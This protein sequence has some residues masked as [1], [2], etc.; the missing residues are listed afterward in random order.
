MLTS[1]FYLFRKSDAIGC[2]GNDISYDI[3]VDVTLI[4]IINNCHVVIIIIVALIG[5]MLYGN[6]NICLI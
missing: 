2:R 6:K 1:T 4:M 3:K 5:N